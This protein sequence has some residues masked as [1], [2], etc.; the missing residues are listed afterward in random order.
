MQYNDHRPT[1]LSLFSGAGGMDLG[2]TQAGFNVLACIE[3]DPYCCQTLQTSLCKE[4]PQTLVIEADIRT[5]NPVELMKRL[6]LQP[7]QLDLL[8][9]GSPCQSFSQIGKRSSL[10]D[11]RGE[12]LFQIIRFAEIFRPRAIMAEQVKGLLSAIDDQGKK[13]G[14]FD[15][16]LQKFKDVGYVP[17]W[18]VI[19]A[20]DYGVPQLRQRVFVISTL[21]SDKFEFPS[22]THIKQ[23]ANLF[24]LPSYTTVGEALAGLGEPYEKNASGVENNH[25]DVTPTRDRVRIHGVPEGSHLAAQLHLPIEQRCRL[26]KK[27]TT[28]FRRLSRSEP[29]ITLRGGEAFYHPIEDRYLTPREY[30]RL[31]GYP[32]DYILKGPIRGRT[33]TVRKLDQHRQVAN[34]VPPPVA[35][36]I[37]E[38][39]LRTLECQV[40]LKS[41]VIPPMI[42]VRKQPITDA[43]PIVHLWEENVMEI[44]AHMPEKLIAPSDSDKPTTIYSFQN[45]T[46]APLRPTL[47]RLIETLIQRELKNTV[48]AP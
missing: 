16:F 43:L 22:P 3:L 25:I 32:D 11:E 6:N 28:K 27:D 33:G 45:I 24:S 17:Q 34:S 41:S 42:T 36:H 35:K 15:L 31:H 8:F 47:N 14:V 44:E 21:P 30:M 48:I 13:G 19:N 18:S 12:L 26:T 9:G 39:I 46:R 2:V 38:A 7:G 1:A 37:S 10:D 5:I 29:S 20:A 23:S 40:F 4:N